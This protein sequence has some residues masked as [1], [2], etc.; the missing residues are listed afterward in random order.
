MEKHPGAP[1]WRHHRDGGE[2]TFC[3]KPCTVSGGGKSEI[4]KSLRDYMIYGPIFVADLSRRTSI[5]SRRFSQKDYSDRWS[6]ER[7]DQ[8][9]LSAA[10]QPADSQPGALAGQRD[11][12]ADAHRAE[13]TDEYNAWL[14]SIPNYIYPIVFII[15]RFYKPEWKGD[16]RSH[17][18]VDIV[19]GFPGHELKFDGSKAGRHV[20]ARRAAWPGGAGGRTRSGRISP[21]A[22]KIQTED[23]ISAS[24]V[25]PTAQLAHECR[26]CERMSLQICRSIANIGCSSGPTTRSI[27]GWTSRP[28]WTWRG[29]T[30]SF[31]ISSR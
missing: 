9:G 6:A 7:T 17:F 8:A 30:I 13:Y 4:S 26:R 3:H 28:K 29:R 21:P 24:V 2:G 16:W 23:D 12:A 20:S 31:P 25:V 15:K 5:W 10:E 1:S 19:N 18:G 11:Q 27:A 14:A 22:A